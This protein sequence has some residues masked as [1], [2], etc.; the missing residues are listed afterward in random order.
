MTELVTPGFFNDE[1][2]E[3]NSNNFLA[4]VHFGKKSPRNFI[5]RC[6]TGEFLTAQGSEEYIDKL[7]QNFQPS[8]VL[9]QATP[10][11]IHGNFG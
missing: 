7:L 6:F 1:V 11:K 4:A 2:L 5:F 9:V 3:S 10:S 8:E